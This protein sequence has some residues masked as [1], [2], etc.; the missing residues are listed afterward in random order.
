M[1][2]VVLI[3]VSLKFHFLVLDQC[4]VRSLEGIDLNIKSMNHALQLGDISLSSINLSGSFLNLLG[5]DLQLVVKRVGP[6]YEGLS[7][8]VQDVDS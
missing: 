6:V 2:S 7:L 1:S 3:T 4:C 8:F 5:S